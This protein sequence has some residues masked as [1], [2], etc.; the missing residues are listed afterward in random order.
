MPGVDPVTFATNYA[1]VIGTIARELALTPHL[2]SP[3]P[4]K[5]YVYAN[6]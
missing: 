4:L 6:P 3:P 2:T 5:P 1:A